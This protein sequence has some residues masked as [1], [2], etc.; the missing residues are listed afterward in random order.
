[1][2]LS[3]KVLKKLFFVLIFFFFVILKIILTLKLSEV[4][5]SF[6]NFK[7]FSDVKSQM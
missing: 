3:G 6:C 1:M 7:S 5:K 2:D 4:S